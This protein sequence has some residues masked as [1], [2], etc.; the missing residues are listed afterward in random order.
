MLIYY[1]NPYVDRTLN[2]TNYARGGALTPRLAWA[3]GEG[4]EQVE[5]ALTAVLS[6]AKAKDG[7]IVRRVVV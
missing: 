4:E 1:V 6:L 7:G 5:L 3:G 2:K